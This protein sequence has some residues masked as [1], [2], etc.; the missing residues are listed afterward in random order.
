VVVVPASYRT[1]YIS[2]QIPVNAKGEVV[3]KGDFRQQ[4]VQVYENLK[5]ALTSAGATFDNV[6]KMT[7]YVANLNTEY[8]TVIREVRSNYLNK[9]NPPANTTVGIATSNPDI[10]LEVEAIAAVTSPG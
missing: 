5:K 10:L 8:L 4:V 2:G 3:G 9:K 7:T 1:I 6:I